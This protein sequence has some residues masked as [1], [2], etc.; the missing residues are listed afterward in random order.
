MWGGVGNK[1]TGFDV[2]FIYKDTEEFGRKYVSMID[3]R[4]DI[5]RPYTYGKCVVVN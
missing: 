4:D 5:R 3:I 2:V 1:N